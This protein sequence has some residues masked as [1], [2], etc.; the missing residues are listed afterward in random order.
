M[1]NSLI[2]WHNFWTRS[3]SLDWDTEDSLAL[4][5]L[6]VRVVREAVRSCSSWRKK[7][8]YVLWGWRPKRVDVVDVV[9]TETLLVEDAPA[10]EE[11]LREVVEWG[12]IVSI[13]LEVVGLIETRW[14]RTVRE[15]TKGNCNFGGLRS[16]SKPLVQ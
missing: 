13:G 16:S 14:L 11:V 9:V 5:L 3:V 8:V 4:F 1:R 2:W 15:W 7:K 12:N 6:V 10:S